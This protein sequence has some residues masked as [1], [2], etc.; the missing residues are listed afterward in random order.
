MSSHRIYLH[1]K[2][3]SFETKLLNENEKNNNKLLIH[4]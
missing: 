1:T 4:L 2:D 3:A